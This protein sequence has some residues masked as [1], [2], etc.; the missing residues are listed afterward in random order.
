MDWGSMEHAFLPDSWVLDLTTTD[1]SVCFV[2]DAV[3]RDGHPLFYWPPAAGEQ[4][5]YALMRWCLHGSVHWN[6]GP[7]RDVPATDARGE[8]DFGNIDVW[9]EL[10]NGKQ[11][12]EGEWGS[13]IVDVR[14]HSVEYLDRMAG[15][16]VLRHPVQQ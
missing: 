12:L 7:N 9:L 13:V 5:P 11:L 4:Y 16:T 14:S 2:L 15:G 10:D 6:S 3:L 8:Q 1:S